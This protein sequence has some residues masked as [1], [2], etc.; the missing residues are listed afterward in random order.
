M[1]TLF[2]RL[3]AGAPEVQPA[4]SGSV[5]VGYNAMPTPKLA[6]TGSACENFGVS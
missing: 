5:A 3:L 1:A 2:D 6:A 4:F